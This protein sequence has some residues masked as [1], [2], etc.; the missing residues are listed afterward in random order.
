MIRITKR[1]KILIRFDTIPSCHWHS[2]G[3]GGNATL[4][5][6]AQRAINRAETPQ[7][8]IELLTD[9]GFE[10]MEESK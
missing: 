2:V 10:V 5:A 4:K 7:E 1:P 9:A 3:W 8:V 6:K